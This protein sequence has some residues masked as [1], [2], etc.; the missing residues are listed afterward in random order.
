MVALRD[1]LI[2]DAGED[3]ETIKKIHEACAGLYSECDKE[4]DAKVQEKCF[5]K[6]KDKLN[7]IGKAKKGW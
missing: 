7:K 2:A 4:K 6:I 3:K 5:D 1:K